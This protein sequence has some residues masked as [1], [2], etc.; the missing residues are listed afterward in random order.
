MRLASCQIPLI[1]Q[2]SGLFLERLELA[3]WNRSAINLARRETRGAC[4]AEA[5]GR[6]PCCFQA[7]DEAAAFPLLNLNQPRVPDLSLEKKGQ[8][9]PPLPHI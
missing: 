9:P 3:A 4:Q 1:C 5:H 8:K 7:G 6:Q 2:C